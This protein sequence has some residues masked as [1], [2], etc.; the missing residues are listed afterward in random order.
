MLVIVSRVIFDLKKT[1]NIGISRFGLYDCVNSI[2]TS[3]NAK[4]V[5]Q[6]L[7]GYEIISTEQINAV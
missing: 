7:I 5:T 1:G 2:L 4:M 6:K 3:T